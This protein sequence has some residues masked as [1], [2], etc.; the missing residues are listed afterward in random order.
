[1]G[2]ITI[3][4]IGVAGKTGSGF[5][6]AGA[7]ISSWLL[8]CVDDHEAQPGL[9]EAHPG[10][11]ARLAAADHYPVDVSGQVAVDLA[12]LSGL[13][14]WMM[15]LCMPSVAWWVKRTVALVKP[16][17]VRPSRYS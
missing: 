17:D 12:D 4:T 15:A 14:A 3:L 8:G 9:P 2:L 5:R 7:R 6:S 10:G 13:V 11:Q 1:M 16:A